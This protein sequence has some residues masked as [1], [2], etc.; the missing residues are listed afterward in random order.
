MMDWLHE[1]SIVRI[2]EYKNFTDSTVCWCNFK[3]TFWSATWTVVECA[4]DIVS[5]KHSP[6]QPAIKV[7]ELACIRSNRH[8]GTVVWVQGWTSWTQTLLSRE[9]RVWVQSDMGGCCRMHSIVHVRYSSLSGMTADA[10]EGWLLCQW[11][12]DTCY[13]IVADEFTISI[14]YWLSGIEEFASMVENW[15]VTRS[16]KLSR[17]WGLYLGGY[18]LLLSVLI[19]VMNYWSPSEWEVITKFWSNQKI[20][21][22]V[23]WSMMEAWYIC[24]FL[25]W[26]FIGSEEVISHCSSVY[27][28]PTWTNFWLLYVVANI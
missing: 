20:E 27:L 7:N 2:R 21:I 5:R 17:C 23:C 1:S 25:W 28:F 18:G 24:K 8:A 10:S 4:A 14:G 22:V 19:E 15:E 12:G 6:S 26:C 13:R 11:W 9:W 16:Y 3:P